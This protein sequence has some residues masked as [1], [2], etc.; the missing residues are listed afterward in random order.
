MQYL[1][2]TYLWHAVSEEAGSYE[3]SSRRAS[4]RYSSSTEQRVTSAAAEEVSASS[5]FTIQGA[6]TFE[7]PVFKKTAKGITIERK[8]IY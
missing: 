4:S 8:C 2:G 1:I 3:S 5:A 7:K 6:I